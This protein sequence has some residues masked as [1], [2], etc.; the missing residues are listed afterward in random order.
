MSLVPPLAPTAHTLGL[1]IG[2]SAQVRIAGDIGLEAV[3]DLTRLTQ[4]LDLLGYMSVDVDLSAVTFLDSSGIAPLVEVARRRRDA[5]LSPVL[6]GECS[7]PARFFLDAA[8]LDGRPYL[9]IDAWDRA[10][11]DVE[12]PAQPG[13]ATSDVPGENPDRL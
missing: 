10:V 9:D 13:A 1:T 3:A 8:Q 7:P 12:G 11:R 5:Q 2:R 6:V 4:S